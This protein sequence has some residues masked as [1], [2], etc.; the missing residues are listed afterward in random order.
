MQIHLKPNEKI[1][2]V[3]EEWILLSIKIG[4]TIPMIY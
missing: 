4:Y 3:L 1:R 2:G